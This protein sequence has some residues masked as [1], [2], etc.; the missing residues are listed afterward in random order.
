LGTRL[1]DRLL[2]A[3]GDAILQEIYGHA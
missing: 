1:G 2:A 3:G